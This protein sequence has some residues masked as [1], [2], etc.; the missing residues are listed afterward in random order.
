MRENAQFILRLVCAD[1]PTNCG[2]MAHEAGMCKSIFAQLP[3]KKY[4]TNPTKPQPISPLVSLIAL[5]LLAQAL[6]VARGASLAQP[7]PSHLITRRFLR[8]GRLRGGCWL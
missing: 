5:G 3:F 1:K 7:P 4:C 2:V 6:R 8:P